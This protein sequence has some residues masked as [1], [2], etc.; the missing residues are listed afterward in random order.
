MSANRMSSVEEI[1]LRDVM[2][3]QFSGFYRPSKKDF[4]TLWNEGTIVLD[5][6]VLLDLYRLP[7]EAQSDYLKLLQKVKARLWL[8]H[9]VALEFQR[10]RISVYFE[11]KQRFMDIGKYLSDASEQLEDKIKR[12]NLDTRH[13]TIKPEALIQSIGEAFSVVKKELQRLE[14]LHAEED[15]DNEKLGNTINELFMGRFGAPYKKEEIQE[16]VKEG[17]ER[18]RKQVPPGYMDIEKDKGKESWQTY[19]DG[20][21]ERKYGDLLLWNQIID[22]AKEKK[23]KKLMFVTNDE[24]EDWWWKLEYKG[25]KTI[26]PR[27]ELIEEIC[28]KAKV[29]LFYMYTSAKFLQYGK[30][31]LNVVVKDESV[32]QVR[33]TTESASLARS[34]IPHYIIGT[35]FGSLNLGVSGMLNTG[36]ILENA[37]ESWIKTRYPGFWSRNDYAQFNNADLVLVDSLSIP[38]RR[39]CV[40]WSHASDSRKFQKNPF[41]TTTY[42]IPVAGAPLNTPT[43][44]NTLTSNPLVVSEFHVLVIVI[45]N[46]SELPIAVNIK[47]GVGTGRYNAIHIVEIEQNNSLSPSV[48]EY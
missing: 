38:L 35:P 41:R 13:P 29:E 37:I 44:I 3:E 6:N 25:S 46:V 36:S 5:A 30:D 4:Q 15:V 9:Q 16:I 7:S 14:E 22:H 20:H 45:A 40:Y 24:K 32:E 48:L 26:G 42:S 23:I 27:P 18:Y 12:L 33:A 47:N 17:V 1:D 34:G 39:M 10:N 11:Q 28:R 19:G 8:P 2:K 21:F 31:Y 43:S